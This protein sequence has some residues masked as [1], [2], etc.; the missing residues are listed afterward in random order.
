MELKVLFRTKITS[1]C[2]SSTGVET[3]IVEQM[4]QAEICGNRRTRS[5]VRSCSVGNRVRRSPRSF[6]YIPHPSTQQ[7]QSWRF[8]YI[9]ATWLLVNT[10]LGLSIHRPVLLR[11]CWPTS[12]ITSRAL[13]RWR[14]PLCRLGG[15]SVCEVARTVPGNLNNIRVRNIIC[16]PLNHKIT[17]R[18]VF[19]FHIDFPKEGFY[20]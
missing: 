11:P 17:Q 19:K 4:S 15:N 13:W 12:R 10:S 16:N 8:C 3:E 1:R 9:S 2:F 6:Y 18:A 14:P 5:R 7:Q 20:I